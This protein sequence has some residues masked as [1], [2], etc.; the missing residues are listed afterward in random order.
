[1]GVALL[2]LHGSIFKMTPSSGLVL[3]TLRVYSVQGCYW[4]SLKLSS[5]LVLLFGFPFNNMDN[6]LQWSPRPMA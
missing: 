4:N 1:M 2:R 3:C 6:C 5:E